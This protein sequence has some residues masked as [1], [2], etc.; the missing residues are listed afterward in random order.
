M[1]SLNDSARTSPL[2]IF[3]RS[4]RR[5]YIGQT[6]SYA[7]DGLRLIAIPLLVYRLTGSALSV[8][9]TYA[10]EFGPFALF[11]RSAMRTSS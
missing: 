2:G 6:F 3:A 11:G 1:S 4:F 7:G 10:L 5:Y 8:G 9:L